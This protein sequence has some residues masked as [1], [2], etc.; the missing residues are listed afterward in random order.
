MISIYR[1]LSMTG[2]N[3]TIF[4]KWF[5]MSRTNH[6]RLHLTQ[7]SHCKRQVISISPL[8]STLCIAALIE[9]C[10]GFISWSG[11]KLHKIGSW[12]LTFR[13]RLC[14]GIHILPGC[15]SSQHIIDLFKFGIF[16]TGDLPNDIVY[17]RAR[18]ASETIT[19]LPLLYDQ[20]VSTSGTKQQHGWLR[21][22][23]SGREG[24]GLLF[25]GTLF[26]VSIRS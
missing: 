4:I 6:E 11:L 23:K 5:G 26:L 7:L 2:T 10:H 17:I 22:T 14:S 16:S 12:V 25:A 24:V 13:A 9:C 3:Y 1:K 15:S 18:V 21:L 8:V 20:H 19:L